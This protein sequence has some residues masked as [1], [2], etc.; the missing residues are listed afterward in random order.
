MSHRLF[1]H[2]R[3]K[4]NAL[5]R[6]RRTRSVSI[7]QYGIQSYGENNDYPQMVSDIVAASP[8]GGGCLD[9]YRKFVTGN[10]FSDEA[11][12]G[13]VINRHGETAD[14][15]LRLAAADLCRFGG[16]SLHVN[17]D[18]AGNVSEVQHLPFE[19]CRLLI[20][21]DGD[22][23][24]VAVHPDWARRD[25]ALR[26]WSAEDI[27]RF[28][29]FAPNDVKDVD[30]LTFGGQVL[31]FSSAGRAVYPLPI[32][33]SVLTDMS[34]EEGIQNVLY[35]NVRHNF[36]PAGA[37]IDYRNNDETD[38]EADETENAIKDFQGDE[39][40]AKIMYIQV[41]S[42]EEKPE[43]IPFAANNY[44]KEF[45]VTTTTIREN[46]GKRF[47]QPPIL[48]A[49][50]VG[51]NFGA[52]A[53]KNA[54]DYYNSATIDERNVLSEQFG[55]VFAHCPLLAEYATDI[56]PLRY[57]TQKT[58]AERLGEKAT[59]MMMQAVREGDEK[60][61]ELISELYGL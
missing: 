59:E 30:W 18:A 22:C 52:D 2:Y 34:A 56:E 40:A 17:Y 33:D 55:A 21:E 61:I 5:K 14:E 38:E 11:L 8:T 26:A 45:Q 47:N 57:A 23:N 13:A 39:K 3:M 6:E 42:A 49:D 19:M 9:T 36:L 43:F 28:P 29:F 37:L 50:D 20:N 1:S 4:A 24:G 31:W 27:M 46:I 51:S 48:R 15:V 58:I 25:T 35:R 7:R 32:Y 12:G 44:D 53:V 54:Y 60:T 10:C 41:R 16:F